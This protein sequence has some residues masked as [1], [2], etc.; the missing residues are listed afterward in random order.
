M[1]THTGNVILRYDP[2]LA[3]VLRELNA[4]FPGEA[5]VFLRQMEHWLNTNSGFFSH[6][7]TRHWIYNGYKEW[8][9]KQLTSL[10]ETQFG[11]MVRW[12]V[13]TGIL[14]KTIF[15][16]IKHDLDEAPPVAWQESNTRTWLT[17]CVERTEELT[18]WRPQFSLPCDAPEQPPT[19]EDME[20][21]PAEEEST[22]E[23]AP[24][25]QESLSSLPGAV[26]QNESSGS[27]DLN[28]PFFTT[29]EPSIYKENQKQP[30]N[31]D[32]VSINGEVSSD[33]DGFDP[34][35]NPSNAPVIPQENSQEFTK[36]HNTPDSDKHSAP[37]RQ[38]EVRPTTGKGWNC[39][40]PRLRREF[41]G[42]LMETMP[43]IQSS[44]HA[45]NWC[46]KHPEDAE[47]RWDDFMRLKNRKKVQQVGFASWNPGQHEMFV[48]Q[49]HT[50]RNS[51]GIFLEMFNERHGTWLEWVHTNHP[52]WL[53]NVVT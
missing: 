34:T 9:K 32:N 30:I 4:P 13:K 18:G 38:S 26:L 29:E 28:N 20:D 44:A 33:S 23:E 46:N 3:K 47:L 53:S 43:P 6:K 50:A 14:E 52:D 39:P 24:V 10:S 45:S 41:M 40:D 36:P 35:E 42:W 5:A 8:I 15:A 19:A 11:R 51:G 21:E 1:T 31:G 25:P 16:H 22:V 48:R 27:A 12:L 17:F 37:P 49:Y 7:G 2:I